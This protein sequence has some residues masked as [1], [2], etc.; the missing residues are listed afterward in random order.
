VRPGRWENLPSGQIYTCPAEVNGVYVADASVGGPA[1]AVAGILLRSPVRIEV[2]ASAC[3]SL[4]CVDRALGAALEEALRAER[5]G[6]KVGMVVL[7]TNVGMSDATGELVADQNL[8]GLHIGFGATFAE[9]TGATWDS[10]SQLL[11]TAAG[12]D[13]D[14]DGMPLLRSGRYLVL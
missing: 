6:D 14:L 2:K 3:K 1:G 8:P 13:V 11:L 9:Q 10:P 4:Q 7:G 5:N 12:T